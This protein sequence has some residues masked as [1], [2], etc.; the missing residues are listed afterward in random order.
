MGGRAFAFTPGTVWRGGGLGSPRLAFWRERFQSLLGAGGDAGLSGEIT[1]EINET[2]DWA[3]GSEALGL[4]A[5]EAY[6]L[7]VAEQSVRITARGTAGLIWGLQT[8]WQL[9]APQAGGNEILLEAQVIRD[10]PQYAHRGLMLDVARHFF[11]LETVKRLLDAMSLLKLNRFHWHLTDEQGWRIEIKRYPLLTGVGSIRRE[12]RGDGVVHQGYYTQ[13]EIAEA[14]QYAGML[15]IEIIPEIDMPGHF[16]AAVAAY[17]ELSCR[18]EPIE[19]RTTFG[20]FP[21]IACAGSEQTYEFLE[22]VLDEVCALFPGRFVHL[23]GDEVPKVRWK[24]CPACREK[25]RQE[26]F[27]KAGLL[28][29]HM[30]NRLARF[31]R[32]RGKTAICWNDCVAAGGMDNSVVMQYW[33]GGKNE[34]GAADEISGGRP[35][36]ISTI[37]QYY[38]DYPYGMTGLK[39]AYGTAKGPKGVRPGAPVMGIEAALWTEYISDEGTLQR[40]LFPRLSAVAES[41]WLAAGRQDYGDFILRQGAL[42]VL[43]RR[44]GI[45]GAPLAEASGAGFAAWIRNLQFI[46][47]MLRGL[48]VKMLGTMAATALGK[49]DG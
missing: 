13:R 49:G 41:A 11:P 39:K 4:L 16:G 17:P 26:G 14:V 32:E 22:G 46:R 3:G 7:E 40:M 5:A 36:V 33:L 8:L 2:G 30:M 27:E 10:A 34:K 19:V 44:F 9:M 43:L 24:E 23:G 20:I 48:D 12:T 38:F 37:G 18:K 31:V 35:T 28:Q 47:N 25:M 1:L 6:C 21:E 45:Q 42:E 29:Q 15:G